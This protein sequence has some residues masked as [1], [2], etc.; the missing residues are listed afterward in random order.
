LVSVRAT[1]GRGGTTLDV[2]VEVVWIY[3]RSP[4][5]KVPAGVRKITFDAPKVHVRVTD[6]AKVERIIRWFDGLPI[7]PPGL[8]VPCTVPSR[9]PSLA[10]AF[11]SGAGTV[12]AHAVVPPYPSGICTQIAFTIGRHPQAA[13]IDN[14]YRRAVSRGSFFAKVQRLLG[15]KLVAH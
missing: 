6:A 14:P 1:S 9:S 11:R 8:N 5:E 12:L 2:D 15:V 3:P 7:S 13:L 4:R 10:L